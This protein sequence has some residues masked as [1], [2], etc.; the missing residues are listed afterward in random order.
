M[1]HFE[2]DTELPLPPARAWEKLS[3]ARFLVQSVPNVESI[4]QSEADKAVCTIRP[5]FAFVRG[6]LELTV[7]VVESI[8]DSS[9]RLLVHTKGVG[10]TSD[11]EATLT[12]TPQG[13]GAHVHWTAEITNLGGLLKAVPQGL[14]KAAAQRVIGDVWTAVKGRIDAGHESD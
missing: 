1:M 7:Q 4:A 8:R 14:V 2:G 9:V 5:G 13:N 3:D 10:S 6:T 12:L 11:V